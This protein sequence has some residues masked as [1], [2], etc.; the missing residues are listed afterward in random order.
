MYKII[1]IPVNISLVLFF[2]IIYS[3][4]TFYLI[5][6]RSLWITVIISGISFIIISYLFTVI[7]NFL[8]KLLYKTFILSSYSRLVL[9]FYQK[10]QVS[11]SINDFIAIIKDLLEDKIGCSVIFT[12]TKNQNI[13]YFSPARISSSQI[14][15]KTIISKYSET[16]NGLYYFKD[17]MGPVKYPEKAC[18]FLLHYNKYILAVFFRY[19]VLFDNNI[20]Y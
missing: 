16:G 17:D 12:H 18:G 20:I 6:G 14:N 9:E 2:S 11:F 10:I 13:I 7:R 5:N 4:I 1:R 3:V 15:Q 8:E 19:L